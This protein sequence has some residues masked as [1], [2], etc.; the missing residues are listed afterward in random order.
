MSFLL[1]KGVRAY[2]GYRHP[3]GMFYQT[4]RDGDKSRD[5]LLF[6]AFYACLMVGTCISGM[7]QESDLE[8]STFYPAGYPEVFRESKEFIASLVVE[9]EL[10][11]L[12]TEDYSSRDFERE[13][14]KLLD[15]NSP[16]RLSEAA[17]V[18]KANLYAAGGFDFLEEY[19]QPKPVNVQD[20]LL[21]FHDM[22]NRRVSV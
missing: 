6:D 11:R 3:E 17:G 18:E 12:D 1:H 21:R 19:L 8:G 15:V 7:G 13:I 22:W 5:F 9:A 4:P 20:F 10:R 14:A 16:T 2:F